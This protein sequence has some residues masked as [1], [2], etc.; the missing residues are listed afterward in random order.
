MKERI[1]R[2]ADAIAVSGREQELL[3]LIEKEIAV[4]ADISYDVMG[5]LYVRK[6]GT[7]E[8]NILAAVSVDSEGFFVNYAKCGEKTRIAPTFQIT[9]YSTVV[10]A[11]LKGVNL[12]GTICSEKEKDI[13]LADIYF[14]PDDDQRQAEIGDHLSFASPVKENEGNLIGRRVAT[15]S[16]VSSL[17]DAVNNCESDNTIT[18]VF[19]VCGIPGGRGLKTVWYTAKPSKAIVLRTLESDKELP[20]LLAKDGMVLSDTEMFRKAADTLEKE[21]IEHFL[22]AVTDAKRDSL[23]INL[24]GAGI[25]TLSLAIPAKDI[26]ADSEKVSASAAHK[27]SAVIKSLLKINF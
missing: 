13:K 3:S 17:I 7:G 22:G 1:I 20:L 8:E 16:L 21:K 9:D 27:A 4:K 6:E 5:N 25:P 2:I 10:G 14:Q 11:K 15:A 12:S 24:S 26:G 18:A 19:A 23:S